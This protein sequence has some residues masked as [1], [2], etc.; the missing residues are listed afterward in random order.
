MSKIL[1][2]PYPAKLRSGIHNAKSYPHWEELVLML[3]EN[4]HE[5]IQIGV[6]GEVR[7][8]GCDQFVINW[9]YDKLKTLMES[10]DTFVSVDSFWPHFCHYH[11]LPRGV[12]LWGK[13]DHRVWGYPENENLLR[14][15]EHLREFQYQDWE[16][17]EH[18][19][20]AF[21]PPKQVIWAV[22][23]I[24]DA[25]AKGTRPTERLVAVSRISELAAT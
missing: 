5:I 21:V 7:I 15:V 4:G 18:D 17:I 13:S 25:S 12:V 6:Q 11:R 10:C 19:P 2:S 14:G 3:K 1:I 9:P 23:R 22:E 16:T 8:V 24:L 20:R